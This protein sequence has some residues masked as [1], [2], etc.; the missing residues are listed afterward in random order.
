[1][2]ETVKFKQVGNK[3]IALRDGCVI[4]D[5]DVAALCGV[6]T[7]R[8][9]LAVKNNPD[10][11]PQGYIFEPGNREFANLR[12]KILTANLTKTRVNPKAFTED[13][14][15]PDAFKGGSV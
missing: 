2:D 6:K 13:W 11:F 8:V 10:R 7:K 4:L 14:R 1:M 15:R 5:R 12:S 3:I 9:N